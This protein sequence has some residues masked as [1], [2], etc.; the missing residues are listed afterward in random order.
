MT[1]LLQKDCLPHSQLGKV[2][3]EV[4]GLDSALFHQ[5]RRR[6]LDG[7]SIHLLLP[8]RPT[9]RGFR[10]KTGLERDGSQGAWDLRK[11]QCP[12]ERLG[13]GRDGVW[14]EMGPR[15]ETGSRREMGREKDEVKENWSPGYRCRG[16]WQGP[17]N[18]AGA[19]CADPAPSM[20]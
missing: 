6:G 14:G 1:C 13:L 20:L 2:E 15:G 5:A 8:V 10:R 4:T 17:G 18:S 11:K 3:I 7:H 16:A 9:T 12:G 19:Q